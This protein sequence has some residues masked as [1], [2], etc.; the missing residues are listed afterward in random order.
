VV[1][2]REVTFIDAST[3]RVKVDKAER[4]EHGLHLLTDRIGSGPQ[5]I[6]QDPPGEVINGR[7][8][9]AL[10][11]LAAHNT[12]PL[13]HLGSSYASHLYRDRFGTAALNHRVVD[14]GEGRR[15]FFNAPLTV[16]GLLCRTRAISRPPLPVR[17]SS[18][19]C[20]LTPGTRPW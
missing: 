20:R 8:P 9:P 11:C 14:R 13:L 5:T 10:A 7:P 15:L 2:R 18:T 19:I 17:V 1:D 12:P 4:L 6:R 16:V 3:T